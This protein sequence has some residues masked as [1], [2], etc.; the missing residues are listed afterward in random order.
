MLFSRYP[1]PHDFPD[2]LPPPDPVITDITPEH[3]FF[4]RYD[5]R[6][7]IWGPYDFAYVHGIYALAVAMGAACELLDIRTFRTEY[8]NGLITVS[9]A[10]HQ[11]ASAPA[12]TPSSREAL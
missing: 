12:L 4:Y 10:Q 9:G 1:Q 11:M 5:S 7:E 6:P 3:H 8:A 2:P